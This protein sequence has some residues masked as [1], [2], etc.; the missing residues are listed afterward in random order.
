MASSEMA[1]KNKFFTA[2]AGDAFLFSAALF[3]VV[4]ALVGAIM[5]V[6]GVIGPDGPIGVL[7]Q[8]L[9]GTGSLLGIAA[10]I[11]GPVVAWKLHGRDFSST[12][13]AGIALGIVV[14][15]FLFAAG[16]FSLVGAAM[17]IGAL[18]GNEFVGLGVALTVLVVGFLVIVVRLDIDAARDMT[19]SRNEHRRLDVLRFVAT[20]VLAV[21]AVGVVVAAFMNPGSEVGEAIPFAIIAGIQAGLVTAIADYWVRRAERKQIDAGAAISA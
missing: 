10:V 5:S 21:Y 12:S 20:G 15:G 11:A 13:I 7:G 17:G 18:A 2:V 19:P 8:V 1:P 4:M 3:A 14:S 16:F 6:A 9:S